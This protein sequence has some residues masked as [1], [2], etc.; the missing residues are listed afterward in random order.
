MNNLDWHVPLHISYARRMKSKGIC[1]LFSYN[2]DNSYS[3]WYF[4]LF[5]IIELKLKELACSDSSSLGW[6]ADFCSK[7]MLTASS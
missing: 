7:I 1:P 2:S 4:D 5:Y 6:D 3:L